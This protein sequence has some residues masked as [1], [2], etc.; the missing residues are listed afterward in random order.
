MQRIRGWR[1]GVCAG[2]GADILHHTGA[3]VLVKAVEAQIFHRHHPLQRQ[4]GQHRHPRIF[5]AVGDAGNIGSEKITQDI[6]TTVG[7]AERCCQHHGRS[8]LIGGGRFAGM[9]NHGGKPGR[10]AAARRICRRMDRGALRLDPVTDI[11]RHHFVLVGKIIND[12]SLADACGARHGINSQ[13]GGTLLMHDRLDG[14]HDRLA[15]Y[16][17]PAAHCFACINRNTSVR[18]FSFASCVKSSR[19]DKG[20]LRG[21]CATVRCG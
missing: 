7:G 6:L 4:I 17:F 1:Q 16:G 8:H 14:I 10:R 13:R 3:Q 2:E 20:P 15:I 18:V 19:H 9:V 11:G 5:R 12:A 21:L